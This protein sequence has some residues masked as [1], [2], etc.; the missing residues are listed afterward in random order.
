MNRASYVLGASLCF[1]VAA[2]C[3]AILGVSAQEYDGADGGTDGSA[4]PPTT[5]DGSFPD[6][7]VPGP[8]AP[9]GDSTPMDRNLPPCD[10]SL[11]PS[12]AACL[13]NE[14]YGVF[15]SPTGSDASGAGSRTS[16]FASIAKGIAA[17]TGATRRVFV[18]A[19]TYHE[20]VALDSGH[21][22]VSVYGGFAS[23]DWSYSTTNTVT[24]APATAVPAITIIGLVA[25]TAVEDIS[26]T[27]NTAT[28]PGGSSI[29]AFATE[30]QNV[31]F[32]RVSMVAGDG[33]PGGP[34]ATGND[35]TPNTA[36]SGVTVDGRNRNDSRDGSSAPV[37]PACGDGDQSAGGIG[38]Q[39][40]VNI[41][42]SSQIDPGPGKRVACNR[43]RD[44]LRRRGRRLGSAD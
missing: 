28:A 24:V 44:G 42:T 2:G 25:G 13:V 20:A 32:R 37:C 31:V 15:V 1:G 27:A 8:D 22:G 36:P 10:T 3:N 11:D 6:N 14:A 7:V 30:A 5:N 33:A 34:G 26:F 21:D 39:G 41:E 18:C 4:P 40:G 29:A 38:G 19:G 35:Y 43:R 17:A 9:L 16:P 12:A 23:E